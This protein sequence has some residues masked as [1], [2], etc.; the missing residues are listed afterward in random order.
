MQQTFAAEPTQEQTESPEK[1][2]LVPDFNKPIRP[3]SEFVNRPDFPQCALG[4]FV[5]IGGYNG[6]VVEIVK[7]SLKVT[8]EEGTTMSYN[9]NGLRKI[10]GAKTRPPETTETSPAPQTN[11]IESAPSPIEPAAALPEAAV[12]NAQSETII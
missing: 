2:P 10:Y 11:A 4:E 12:E 1:V 3:I 5:D 7:L 6:V 8:S 9:A